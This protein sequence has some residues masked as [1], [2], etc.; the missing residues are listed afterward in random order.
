MNITQSVCAF[1]VLG[2]QHAMR[3]RHII[4]SGLP[5]TLQYVAILFHKRHDF[6]GDGGEGGEVLNVQKFVFRD[7][8]QILSETFPILR[9][10]ERV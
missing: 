7:S 3:M 5:P 9:R 6:L 2:I 4:I 1:L 10:I 8:A